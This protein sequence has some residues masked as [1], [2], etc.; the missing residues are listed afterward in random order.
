MKFKYQAENKNGQ[1]QKGIVE[2]TTQRMA[3]D[4]LAQN[5]LAVISLKEVN[6]FAF[7]ETL[8]GIFSGVKAKEFV[9]FSRQ[10]ATLIDSRVPLLNA[11]QSIAGQTEN[12]NFALKISSI[13]V[14]VDGGSSFSDALSK[15]PETF[16]N[17]Y[18][19]MV[20]AGEAS[21]TLQK[22]LNDLA[23]NMEKNYELTSKL[24]GAMYYPA[25]ILFAMIAVGFLVMTFVMPKLLEILVES[26]VELPLQT[27]ALI[28][29]SGFL[30]NYWWAILIAVFF[31]VF[32]ISYYLKTEDGRKEFDKLIL[33]IP[34][35][36]M[37]LKN[38]YISRFS[39]NL[40]TLIQSGLPITTALAITSEVV[41]NEVYREAIRTAT[42]EIKRGGQI[43]EIFNQYPDLFPPIVVQMIQ[44]GEQT[45]RVEFAL[46]KVAEFY[47]RETDNIVKNFSSLVEPI[48]M[49]FLA[50]GVGLLV[51]A[52]L[53]PIYQVATS[54][55]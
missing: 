40:A 45:G 24:K 29:I 55:Q 4:L 32:G 46:R 39:E 53:L 9:I 14:D 13:I 2:A 37:I 23:D 47:I 15:H 25:F 3:V 48:L 34:I 35:V 11:L 42:E 26:N 17:F 19:N 31:A 22:T 54:I 44:V 50:I 7:F 51:S 49:V 52:V 8:D 12:S 21:G 41:G 1:K 27:K 16:S 10:L 33:K 5:G 20:K 28:W 43:A 38:V 36:K 30:V 6:Q 18:V